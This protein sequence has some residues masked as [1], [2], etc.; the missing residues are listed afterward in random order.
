MKQIILILTVLILAGCTKSYSEVQAAETKCKELGGSLTVI[1]YASGTV[2]G[3]A[4]EIGKL[5]FHEGDF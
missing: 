4:C 1:T 5:R 2:S 3:Y